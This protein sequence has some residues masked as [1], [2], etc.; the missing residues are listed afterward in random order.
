MNRRET[1][2]ND[3]KLLKRIEGEKEEWNNIL[4]E[5]YWDGERNNRKYE[6]GI[7]VEITMAVY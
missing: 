3:G 6:G 5:K 1:G 4:V 2:N 7:K